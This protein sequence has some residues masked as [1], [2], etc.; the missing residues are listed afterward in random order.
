MSVESPCRKLCALDPVTRVCAGCLRTL[1]EI[2][3]WGRMSDKEKRD[4]LRRI[5]SVAGGVEP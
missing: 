1:D 5:E 3:R 2:A 4:V